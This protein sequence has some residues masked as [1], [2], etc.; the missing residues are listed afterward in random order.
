MLKQISL[1]NQAPVS[2]FPID[3]SQ[4]PSQLKEAVVLLANRFFL[5]GLAAFR[6]CSTMEAH[7]KQ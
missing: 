4:Y 3:A 6:A 7:G 5:T 2:V 1:R